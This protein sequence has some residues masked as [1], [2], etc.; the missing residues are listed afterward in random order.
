MVAFCW[1][2]DESDS[3]WWPDLAGHERT[4]LCSRLRRSVLQKFAVEPAHEPDE[5]APVRVFD[6]RP[7]YFV[8]RKT[9]GLFDH[10]HG[11]GNPGLCSP[12]PRQNLIQLVARFV[13]RA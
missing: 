7:L 12:Q 6:E 8:T 1:N 4:A 11:L 3:H 9:G 5:A 10:F 2:G 13:T